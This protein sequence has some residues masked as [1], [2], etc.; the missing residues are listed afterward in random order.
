MIVPNELTKDLNFAD[1]NLRMNSILDMELEQ[2]IDLLNGDIPGVPA[3]AAKINLARLN[4]K[5]HS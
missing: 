3:A 4:L 5:I 2:L 1:Y